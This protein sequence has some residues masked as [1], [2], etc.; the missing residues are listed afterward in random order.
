M[1]ACDDPLEHRLVYYPLFGGTRAFES[2]KMDECHWQDDFL[3][4]TGKGNVDREVPIHRCLAAVKDIILA[5]GPVHKSTLYS[6][7]TRLAERTGIFFRP[8]QLRKTFSTTLY[9]IGVDGR[10]VE[11]FLGHSPDVSSRARYVVISRRKQRE[12]MDRLDYDADQMRL[13]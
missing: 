11:K 2:A 9:D 8:H 13:F 10:S 5:R 1:A 3:R 7:R 6:V 12:D 4:F